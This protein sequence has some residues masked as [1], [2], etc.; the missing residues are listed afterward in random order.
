MTGLSTLGKAL[1]QIKNVQDQQTLLNTLTLQ[2]STG[3]KT[4][5]FSGLGT[6]VLTSKRMRADVSSLE[7]YIGNITSADRRIEQTLNVL[8]SIQKQ[9]ENF[10][11]LIYGLAQQAKHQEGEIVYYDDPMTPDIV[12]QISVGMDSADPSAE[13]QT[14]VDYADQIFDLFVDMTNARDGDRY[15]LSGAETLVQPITDTSMLNTALSSLITDWKGG[16][17][18][19]TDFIADLQDRTTTGGNSNAITDT[20][21]GYDTRL[22]SGNT[23]SVFARV[24]EKVEIDYTVL[25][26]EDAFRD[27][28]VAAAYFKN[29]ELP[30][31][32][33]EVDPTTLAV[34]T[35]GA[36]GATID[37][38]KDNFFEVINA[39]GRQ[40][41]SAIKDITR[42][43]S[44]LE[45]VRARMAE[46]E[47]NHNSQINVFK[48]IINEVENVDIN[49][50]AV[51]INALS[52][53]L[54][55]SFSVTARTQGLTLVNYL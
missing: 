52:I 38:M 19:T 6:D 35:E 31:M 55:A 13:L 21:V 10:S 36:P 4:Q 41:D 18:S 48:D 40:V 43:R 3:K 28:L 33:D 47:D 9:A 5:K 51:S 2:L 44:Q 37:E 46:I 26:T 22:S 54:E 25:G 15:L 45:N 11:D 17:I 12:E 29:A 27:I 34:I 32:I 24:D 42:Y 16:T 49:E 7:T 23:K 8:E 1:S 53:Q 39:M 30:P 14:L 50:I 20:I